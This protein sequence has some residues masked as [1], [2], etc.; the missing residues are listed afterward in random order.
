MPRH[1]SHAITIEQAKNKAKFV[2]RRTGWAFLKPG[3]LL[4]QVEKS[5]GLKKGEKVK[6]IHLIR[7]VSTRWEPL[8]KMLFDP[9]YGYEECKLEGFP[10]YTPD[11]FIEMF[12]KT[13]HNWPIDKDLN[14]IQYEYI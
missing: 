13:H 6:R 8:S 10:D 12:Q 14:R 5:Q 2:T 11:E 4:W 7:V 9:V 1:I 3:V